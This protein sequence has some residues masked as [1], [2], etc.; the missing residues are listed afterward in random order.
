MK[1]LRVPMVAL[2]LLLAQVFPAAAQVHSAFGC[3]NLAGR[4]ALPAIEGADGMFYRVHPD[5]HMFHPFSDQTVADL[6]RLS[7]ALVTRGTTLIY[8]PLPTKALVEP[9]ALPTLASDMGFDHAIAATVFDDIVQRLV[10]GGVLAVNLRLPLQAP[11]ATGTAVIPTD[12]RLNVDGGRRAA[13]VIGAVIAATPGYASQPRATYASQASG[14]VT[15]SSPMR[16]ILQ[17]HCT[18]PL[19]PPVTTTVTTTATDAT[20]APETPPQIVLVGTE[21]ISATPSNLTGFLSEATGLSV[22]GHVVTGG[23]AFA[24]I[25]AY[26]TSPAFED[27]PPAYL[28]WVNPVEH[29]LA[30]AGDLP[31]AEIIA[32]ARGTCRTPLATAPGPAPDTLVITLPPTPTNTLFI[33]ADTPATTARI[34][35]ATVTG[36]AVTRHMVRHPDPSPNGRFYLPLASL[37]PDAALSATVTFNIPTGPAPR[38]AA[39]TD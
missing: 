35:I 17:R 10:A 15:L 29:G 33:D 11:N 2:G 18:L 23:G 8:V 5:L 21:E 27:A 7:D 16:D 13:T 24:A 9:E 3:S 30:A 14:D 25:T 20:L 26:L 22:T 12:Y 4:H 32:A 19:P 38:A 31:I 6:A 37:W 34:D 39:C 36:L 28:V 1:G